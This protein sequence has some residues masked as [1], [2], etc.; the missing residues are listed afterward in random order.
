MSSYP[1]AMMRQCGDLK[2]CDLLATVQL[3]EPLTPTR[4]LTGLSLGQGY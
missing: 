2:L 1:R 3:D 4:G